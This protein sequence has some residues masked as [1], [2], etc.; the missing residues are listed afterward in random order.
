M[1][2]WVYIDGFNLYYRSLKNTPYK[3]L[4]P[5]K[6]AQNVLKP[7]YNIQRIKFFTA[8]VSPSSRNPDVHNRQKIYLKALEANNS[9]LEIIYGNFQISTVQC[10]LNPPLE[11]KQFHQR[12]KIEEKG[13]DVN[14]AVHLLNDAY[15]NEYDC[16]IVISNDS[17]LAEAMNLVQVE[18]KKHIGLIKTGKGRPTVK[19]AQYS[20]FTRN[21]DEK[22]L[23]NGQL[24][25]PV[26]DAKTG[27]ELWKPAVWK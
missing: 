8:R 12:K 5:L 21:L 11:G 24:P 20:N 16:A 25:N 1:R 14:L 27:K 23:K 22:S 13:S 3:W 7:N 17:D 10:Y 15:K 9:N 2:T 19:L 6:A 4:D 26:L 18:K